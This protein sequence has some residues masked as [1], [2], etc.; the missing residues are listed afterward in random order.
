MRREVSFDEV[1]DAQEQFRIIMEA[2]ARPGKINTLPELDVVPPA[3]LTK[4][5]ALV[6][7]GLLNA[8]VTFA[9]SEVNA[10]KIQSYININSAAQLNTQE[11]ADYIFLT[12]Q[13]DVS[14]VEKVKVGTLS[15]PEQSAT[16][17][18]SVKQIGENK[19][20]GALKIIL[21]GPGIKNTTTV[22]VVGINADVLN[23]IRI[24]NQE[25][26]L[27]VDLIVTD[28]NNQLFCIPRSNQFIIE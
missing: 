7:L 4:A 24:I 25:F 12:G 10:E 2:M 26:P 13:E 20:E 11:A 1:F 22:F 5:S 21:S 6:A 16:L 28:V 8:D 17:I 15:Y 27:G 9:C 3:G 14:L 19:T 18:F 23:Q